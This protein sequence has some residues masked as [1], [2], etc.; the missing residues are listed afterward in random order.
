MVD[1]GGCVME[2][3]WGLCGGELLGLCDGEVL[4]LCD[5]EVLGAVWWTLG[6]V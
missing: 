2:R 3:Y 1:T 5:G 4:G 6:A